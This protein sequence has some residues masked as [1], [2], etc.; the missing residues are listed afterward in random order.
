MG[1]I[2]NEEPCGSTHEIDSQMIVGEG[3]RREMEGFTLV[4]SRPLNHEP[5][6]HHSDG[7]TDWI[8]DD[9]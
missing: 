6:N 5:A 4:C 1:S 9:E 3:F 2:E 8:G 7:V